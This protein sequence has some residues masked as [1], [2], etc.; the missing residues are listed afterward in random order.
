MQFIRIILAVVDN[1]DR[2]RARKPVRRPV[3]RPRKEPMK[4]TAMEKGGWEL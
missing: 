4:A 3:Q 2:M 1:Q